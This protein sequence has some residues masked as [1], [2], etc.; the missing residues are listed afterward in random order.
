MSR[1]PLYKFRLYIAGDSAN[2]ALAVQNINSICRMYLPG[3]YEIEHVDVFREPQ[4]ALA[5]LVVM[6][7]TL[8]KLVPLPMCRIVG[9]L[10]DTTTVLSTLGL[11][12]AAAA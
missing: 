8:I 10:S 5:D 7:P 1:R 3:R 12:A 2:S 4:R 9:T 11:A 6:T